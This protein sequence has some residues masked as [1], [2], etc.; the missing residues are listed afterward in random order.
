MAY[1]AY[2]AWDTYP[3]MDRS[4][5]R[6][7]TEFLDTLTAGLTGEHEIF[8]RDLMWQLHN[9]LDYYAKYTKPDLPV[10]DVQSSLLYLP[11]I[12]WDNA[13][14]GRDV[15]LTEGAAA[16]VRA[17]FGDLLP[18]ERDERAPA[19]SL[20]TRVAGLRAGTPYVLAVM[21]SYPETPLDP[22]E[23][24]AIS[25]RLGLRRGLPRG[26]YVV[27]AGRIGEAPVLEQAAETPFRVRTRLDG[28]TV[29]VRIECWI[30][31]DTIRRMGFGHVVVGRQHVLTLDR[32]AS[33]VALGPDGSPLL[34]AW[35][36]GIYQPQ[37]RYVI[38]HAAARP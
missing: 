35:A 12:V 4:R 32:G 16:Q 21:D 6:A 15:V 22:V 3:A 30:P 2:R 23:M 36:G 25:A 18:I 17:A 11:L 31:A 5:D 34:T 8:A 19:T 20:G 29:D 7:P 28:R 33:F 14:M 26:R 1:P 24:T 38:R 13:A 37:A 10:L 9:G 27:V